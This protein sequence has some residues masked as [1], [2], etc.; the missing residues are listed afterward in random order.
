[1]TIQ[2]DRFRGGVW[3]GPWAST[4]PFGVLEVGQDYLVISDESLERESRFVRGDIERIEVKR[5]LPIIGFGIRIV[6]V[7]KARGG[8]LYFWYPS[9]RFKKLI[10]ALREHGWLDDN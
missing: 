1:M 5:I 10:S 7:N 3:T 8:N 6:P 4:W 2:N 9:F